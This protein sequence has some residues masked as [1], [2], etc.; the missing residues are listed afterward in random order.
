MFPL[1][2]SRVNPPIY[3]QNSRV[4]QLSGPEE[5]S[6]VGDCCSVKNSRENDPDVVSANADSDQESRPFDGLVSD[7]DQILVR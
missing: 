3:V 6:N 4:A 1:G 5:V 2:R 7:V